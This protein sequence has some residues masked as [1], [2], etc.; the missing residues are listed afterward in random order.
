MLGV[1]F[2]ERGGR[3]KEHLVDDA[4][5]NVLRKVGLDPDANADKDVKCNGKGR[6]VDNPGQGHSKVPLSRVAHVQLV[7]FVAALH[8]RLAVVLDLL[9]ILRDLVLD[10]VD[11]DVG[12]LVD[13]VLLPYGLVHGLQA[14]LVRDEDGLQ[15]EGEGEVD[16]LRG[17]GLLDV[18]LQ[19]AL[20]RGVDPAK[21]LRGGDLVDFG[22]ERVRLE[23]LL[24]T[25]RLQ[26]VAEHLH[27]PHLGGPAVVVQED[28]D[29]VAPLGDV[30][31]GTVDVELVRLD[32]SPTA[33]HL[34]GPDEPRAINQVDEL[35]RVV[36]PVDDARL[37]VVRNGVAEDV[38]DVL[39]VVELAQRRLAGGVQLLFSVGDEAEGLCLLGL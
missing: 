13:F 14:V 39:D 11:D 27:R 23:G 22:D 26:Q 12:G 35:E 36:G 15:L 4:G 1:G 10:G 24:L 16:V 29:E 6:G 17:G 33:P 19:L 18:L 31:D 34:G 7:D 21:V 2:H 30:G 20:D 37:Q 28:V 25:L 3:V 38:R 5:A 8:E 32:V 9:K